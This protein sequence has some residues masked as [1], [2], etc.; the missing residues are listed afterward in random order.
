MG[1]SPFAFG[2]IGAAVAA[3]V[4]AL[5]GMTVSASAAALSAGDKQCLACHG[6]PGMEKQLAGGETLSLHIEGDGFAQSV[7]SVIGCTGCHADIDLASHP[8]AENPIAT[9]REFS[10]AMVQICRTC[11][12]DQFAQWK[13]SVHAAL[14]REGNPVAPLCT[15]CHSPHAVIKGAA[16]EMDTVPCK[17]CH[18]D[19]FTAYATSVHGVM[20]SS[21]VTAAPLCFGCHGAHD[22]SVPSA[23]Q[24]LKDVCLGC[25]TEARRLAPG[26]G[27][28]MPSCISTWC[29]VRSAMR[30]R[31]TGG[32]ISSS[33]TA[34]R[35]RRFPSRWACRS[36]KARRAPRPQRGRASIRR[37]SG[38]CSARSIA[39]ASKA[40]RALRA[41]WT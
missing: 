10:I 9:K 30:R 7:H 32:S 6:S 18:G 35:K 39:R 34:R 5:A 17:T 13:Q 15:S 31:R 4:L 16:E 37:R 26:L 11:H 2:A 22:V 27:C 28:R 23:A 8:P 29:P 33:M 41:D 12:N 21:G 3:V 38:L 19:I 40:R 24:G 1:R 20:R 36:S 14:V 25:H